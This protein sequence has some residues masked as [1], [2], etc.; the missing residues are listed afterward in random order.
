[1]SVD[2]PLVAFAARRATLAKVVSL[3]GD[4]VG[5]CPA[6]DGQ[7]CYGKPQKARARTS[8]RDRTT[9]E[10]R[11]RCPAQFTVIGDAVAWTLFSSLLSAT[12]SP[13]SATART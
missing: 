1:M 10:G 3:E 13:S 12:C 4:S 11:R 6:T 5:A 9:S 8:S 2:Y 7:H